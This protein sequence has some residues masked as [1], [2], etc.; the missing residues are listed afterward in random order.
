VGGRVQ[1]DLV[2]VAIKGQVKVGTW[3]LFCAAGAC[4]SPLIRP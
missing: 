2:Q 4:I 1:R 3:N